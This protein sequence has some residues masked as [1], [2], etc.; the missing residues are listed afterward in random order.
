MFIASMKNVKSQPLVCMQ[1]INRKDMSQ[2]GTLI[3]GLRD[4]IEE[5]LPIKFKV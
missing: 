4:N 3:D 5:I 1:I 2:V